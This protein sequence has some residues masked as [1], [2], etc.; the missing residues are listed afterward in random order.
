[1]YFLS[2]WRCSRSS[3][4]SRYSLMIL[5]SMSFHSAQQRAQ[6]TLMTLS[7]YLFFTGGLDM[8]TQAVPSEQAVP[9]QRLQWNSDIG[10]APGAGASPRVRGW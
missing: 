5:T 9:A 6:V 1:M 2:I 7:Q 3:M 4:L 10:G 8:G